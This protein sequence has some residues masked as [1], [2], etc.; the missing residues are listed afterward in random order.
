MKNPHKN[1]DIFYL[2]GDLVV[3]NPKAENSCAVRR[4]KLS[5]Q[6]APSKSEKKFSNLT[7]S[8]TNPV[9]NVFGLLKS[10]FPPGNE[11][12]KFTTD[13]REACRKF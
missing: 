13:Y 12:L 9:L 3:M 8:S 4:A 5:K 7:N 10:K 2:Q 1:W 6:T 11:N